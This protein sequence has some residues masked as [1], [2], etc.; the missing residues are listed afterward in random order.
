MLTDAMKVLF[1][2]LAPPIDPCA[3]VHRILSDA[4]TC[5]GSPRARLNRAPMTRYTR[6][7]TPITLVG[8]AHIKQLQE[9]ATTVL[10]SAFERKDG[11][12]ERTIK[13][14]IRPTIRQHTVLK[15]MEI[16]ETVAGVVGDR[17]QVDLEKYD[18]LV[19]VEVYRVSGSTRL[20]SVEGSCRARTD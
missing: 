14:A 17:A 19:L 13:Y 8:K 9:V 7:L 11:E 10:A 5:Q 6:R 4:N 20:C 1:F 16:I 2:A 18:R 15:R 3:L 12:E